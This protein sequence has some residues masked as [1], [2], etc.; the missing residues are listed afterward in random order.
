MTPSS[1]RIERIAG[2]GGLAWLRLTHTS[3]YSVV[4]SEYGA[5]VLS[6]TSPSGDELLFLSE[7][8]SFERGK[9]IRGG[10]PVVFPQFGKGLLSQHGFARVSDWNVIREQVS[11]TGAVSL[12]LRLVVDQTRIPEWPYSCSVELDIVLTDVLLM[13][14]RV[15]NTGFKEL[16]FTSALHN[17]FRIPDIASAEIRGMQGVEFVDL[18]DQRKGSL[19]EHETVPCSGPVDRVYRDSPSL[20]TLTSAIDSRRFSITKE[21]FSDSVIWNPGQVGAQAIAD[22]LPSEYREMICIESANVL[23]PIVLRAGELHTSAQILRVESIV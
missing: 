16:T 14:M 6:W 8:A 5:Q 20:V 13:T 9:P 2:N 23:T 12:T 19:E 15:Q 4:V 11:T 22:L 10:I 17:Y 21:G 7:A 18:L 1:N 3:G